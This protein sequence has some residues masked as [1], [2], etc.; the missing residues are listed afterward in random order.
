MPEDILNQAT[1]WLWSYI[2]EKV[3]ELVQVVQGETSYS[4]HA[5][6]AYDESQ[7][8]DDMGVIYNSRLQDF[9]FNP[10]HMRDLGMRDFARGDKVIRVKDRFLT[11]PGT[12]E[13][14]DDGADSITY[15]A[16][17]DGNEPTWRFCSR[18]RNRIRLHTKRVSYELIAPP[19]PAPPIE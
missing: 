9:L 10:Q 16:V 6:P 1:A 15:E 14:I 12:G 13:L 17:S 11:D 3:A 18:Y 4:L 8:S 7:S 2:D 5:T 19:L